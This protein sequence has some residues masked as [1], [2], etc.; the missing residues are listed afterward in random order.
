MALKQTQVLILVSFVNSRSLGSYEGPHQWNVSATR[1]IF[2][3]H[4]SKATNF[5]ST[6]HWYLPFLRELFQRTQNSLKVGLNNCGFNFDC[7]DL[8]DNCFELTKRRNKIGS[9]RRPNLKLYP[10]GLTNRYTLARRSNNRAIHQAHLN[11][12]NSSND[13]SHRV[14]CSSETILSVVHV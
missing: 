5:Y 12:L 2:N 11:N 4:V 6:Y 3:S 8:R 13:S 10:L 14:S 9:V 7:K 1:Q